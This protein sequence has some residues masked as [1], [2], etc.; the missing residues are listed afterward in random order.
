V[1]K[2]L[3]GSSSSYQALTFCRHAI[4]VKNFQNFSKKLVV[5]DLC[6]DLDQ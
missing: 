4:V 1:L 3:K 6:F 2:N 5:A